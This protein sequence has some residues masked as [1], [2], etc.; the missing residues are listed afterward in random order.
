ML[1][2]ES[3]NNGLKVI[4][5]ADMSSQ[6]VTAVKISHGVEIKTVTVVSAYF[7]YNRPTPYFIAKL[8]VILDRE[9]RTLIGVEITGHSVLWH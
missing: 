6:N 3:M 1:V 5:L 8:R 7:K 9:S 2:Q 4:E